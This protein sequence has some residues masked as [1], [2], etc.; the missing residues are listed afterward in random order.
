MNA[1]IGTLTNWMIKSEIIFLDDVEIF[2]YGIR[3]ICMVGVSTISTLLIGWSMGMLWQAIA[4]YFFYIPLRS[5][6]G[7]YHARTP[8]ACYIYSLVLIAVA[9]KSIDFISTTPIAGYLLIGISTVVIIILAPVGDQNKP[10]T[11]QEQKKYKTVTIRILA[12][13]LSAF[14]VTST[15]SVEVMS[16][17]LIA[18]ST[19]AFMLLCGSGNNN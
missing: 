9:L 18:I 8:I 15:I 7:G 19:V 11:Q 4:F 13:H 16:I 6:A 5:F 1:V 10:L 17:I 14:L 3:Q 12:F 2:N